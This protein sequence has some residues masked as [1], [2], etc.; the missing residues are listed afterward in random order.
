M[1][2]STAV[3][4][5]F[6]SSLSTD[7]STSTASKEAASDAEMAP[8]TTAVISNESTTAEPPLLTFDLPR[9]QVSVR[10]LVR[11]DVRLLEWHGGPDLRAFYEWQWSQHITDALCT[12]IAD[13]NGYPIGQG[14]IH[15]QGKPT[16]PHIPDIQSLRVM[17]AFQGLGIGTQL[18]KASEHLVAARGFAQVS[19]AAGTANA[20][21]QRLY[22]R[23]GYQAIGEP[24]VDEWHYTNA[25]GQVVRVEETVIDLVKTLSVANSD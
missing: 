5:N 25:Q 14:S 16:H 24:Y 10:R 18:L 22:E 8:A 23:L 4:T 1:I 6:S 19:L 12:L 13:F 2:G 11:R 17:P 9:F 7:A 20:A 21:A 15:W 3:K